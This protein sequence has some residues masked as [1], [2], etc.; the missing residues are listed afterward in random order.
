MCV[1]VVFV[2]VVC[3]FVRFPFVRGLIFS[4]SFVNYFWLCFVFVRFFMRLVLVMMIGLGRVCVVFLD[5]L[6]VRGGH[7]SSLGV[8]VVIV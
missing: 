7:A 6:D 3:N 1:C 2:C 4:I 5:C 8:Y